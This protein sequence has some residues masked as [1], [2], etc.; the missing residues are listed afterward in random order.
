MLIAV[1]TYSL[2]T[3]PGIFV[4]RL[5]GD[6]LAA[7][8]LSMVAGIENPSFLALSRD[9]RR[10]LA[11]SE[12]MTN[13]H[14]QLLT[15]GIHEGALTLIDKL[16]Y[17]G[18]GSCFVSADQD[19]RFAFIA[20]YGAGTLL[21]VRLRNDS[22][23]ELVQAI[24][25]DGHG[26][27]QGRQEKSHIHAAQ[28]SPDGRFLICTDLG[29][30]RLYQFHFDPEQDGPLSPFD[31]PYLQ[32]PPGSGPRHLVF[33]QDAMHIY[34]LTELSGEIFTISAP[35]SGLEVIS[36]Q[37]LVPNDYSSV[38]EAAD[39]KIHPHADILYASVR[40]EINELV[41]FKMDPISGNLSFLQRISSEGKS[42]RSILITPDGRLLLAANEKSDGVTIFRIAENGSLTYTQREIKVNS[43][44]SLICL[45]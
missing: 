6:T 26:P 44:A 17:R 15:F 36:K 32:L 42:P 18:G 19:C 7:I 38:V 9:C 12:Q 45:S 23:S 1:G 27:V 39:L 35:G 25:F 33:A 43:P 28:L 37:S 5:E 16:N 29:S 40:G 41:V 22:S 24:T 31:P 13:D 20:N 2:P 3:N 8:Q 11:I 10:I 30:D 21:L 4:Y 34:L 14:G